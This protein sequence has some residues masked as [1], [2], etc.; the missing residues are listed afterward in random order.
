MCGIVGYVGFRRAADLILQGLRRLEYRGYD[1]AGL[2]VLNDAADIRVLKAAGRL[3][4]LEALVHEDIPDSS[5]GIGHTRWA[6]HGPPTDGN[7]HPHLGGCG[8]VAGA[9]AAGSSP[10]VAVAPD[11]KVYVTNQYGRNS[12]SVIDPANG[13]TVT[14]ITTV[15]SLFIY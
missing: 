6:T 8:S 3:A 9:H 1:S 11:G 14:D 5:I 13:N 7:A 10:A 2:A 4:R 15:P 12:V